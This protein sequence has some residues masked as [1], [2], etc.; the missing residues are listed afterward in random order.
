M[1]KVICFI[2]ICFNLQAKV[3]LISEL[4]KVSTIPIINAEINRGKNFKNIKIVEDRFDL[5]ANKFS[6]IED[7]DDFFNDD[8]YCYFISSYNGVYSLKLTNTYRGLD[9]GDSFFFLP[10]DRKLISI[11]NFKNEAI[12]DFGIIEA[13]GEDIKEL[14]KIIG[15][16]RDIA[17]QIGSNS[18]EYFNV[19]KLLFESVAHLK[20]DTRLVTDTIIIKKSESKTITEYEYI[21]KGDRNFSDYKYV[22]NFRFH[23]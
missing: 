16:A 1:K 8:I 18:V 21:Y 7:Y 2:V 14:K 3:D 23:H 15:V 22:I 11:D 5:V 9:E 19:V 13:D 10:D 6:V 4:K 20:H 17:I 12:L